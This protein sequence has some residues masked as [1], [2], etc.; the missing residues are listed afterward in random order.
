MSR[1]VLP[2]RFARSRPARRESACCRPAAEKLQESSPRSVRFLAVDAGPAVGAGSLHQEGVALAVAVD[3]AGE[4]GAK[5]PKKKARRSCARDV[6]LAFLGGPGRSEG[7]LYGIYLAEVTLYVAEV[8]ANLA[9]VPRADREFA[10]LRGVPIL[11]VAEVQMPNLAEVRPASI[12]LLGR[13]RSGR[14]RAAGSAGAS[15]HS[16][17]TS[18]LPPGPPGGVRSLASEARCHRPTVA[19][20]ST[21]WSRPSPRM[22]RSAARG[23]ADVRRARA[24]FGHRPAGERCLGE[25]IGDPRSF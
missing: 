4:F 15:H 2:L 21:R 16:S 1:R 13:L 6:V 9:E 19:L 22:K 12:L 8:P 10:N 11:N 17:Q 3:L 23:C 18:N 7:G 24:I 14:W 20:L 25:R 5:G